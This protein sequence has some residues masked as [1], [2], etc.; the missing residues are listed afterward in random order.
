MVES[1]SGLNSYAG[2]RGKGDSQRVESAVGLYPFSSRFQRSPR[3]KRVDLVQDLPDGWVRF[4]T[5]R[6]PRRHRGQT[7]RCLHRDE[8]GQ[9]PWLKRLLGAWTFGG[10][11]PSRPLDLPSPESV[12]ALMTPRTRSLMHVISRWSNFRNS[13]S[14]T[15]LRDATSILIFQSRVMTRW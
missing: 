9:R 11:A 7:W 10:L 6:P 15:S 12:L 5:M 4:S 14:A 8:K 3:R 2:G 13:L 1:I